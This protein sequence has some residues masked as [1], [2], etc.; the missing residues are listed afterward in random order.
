MPVRLDPRDRP[1]EADFAHREAGLRLP[2]QHAPNGLPARRFPPTEPCTS[3][4]RKGS[5][6]QRLEVREG[7]DGLVGI[8]GSEM[9]AKSFYVHLLSGSYP[10]ATP[11]ASA[12]HRS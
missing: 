7:H 8:E 2:S 5:I 6:D 12:R 11:L 3:V 10:E 9:V 4:W 1:H